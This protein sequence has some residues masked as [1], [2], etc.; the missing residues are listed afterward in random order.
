MKRIDDGEITM[1]EL[2]GFF[3]ELF[4]IRLDTRSFYDSYTDIKSRK[5]ESRIYFLDKLRE[6]L[7]L[8]MQHDDEKERSMGCKAQ[9][10]TVTRSLNRCRKL[11]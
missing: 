6:R 1:N 9:F 2:S 3:G 10:S 7:N 4:G 5:G 8:W 11:S